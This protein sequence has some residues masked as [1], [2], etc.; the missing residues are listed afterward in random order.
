LKFSKRRTF[1][2]ILVFFAGLVFLQASYYLW[3]FQDVSRPASPNCGGVLVYGGEAWRFPAAL[4]RARALQV[5]LYMTG[6]P[7]EIA[8]AKGEISPGPAD[9]QFD[10]Q[11]YTTDQNARHAAA[12]LKSGGFH[13]VELVTSWFHEPR[14]LFL[15]RL[16]LLGTGIKVEPYWPEPI[17]GNWWKEKLFWVE[18]I[19]GWGSL[20][21]V[22]LYQVGVKSQWHAGL[23]GNA[24]LFCKN[25]G[26]LV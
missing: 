20:A 8:Q 2:A 5:P 18:W 3:V 26:K 16:Y 17:P 4:Q 19:K 11:A 9:V 15:T 25:S 14:A 22:L 10:S 13:H 23:Q 7:M 21:R 24:P 6:A 12:Y 1:I